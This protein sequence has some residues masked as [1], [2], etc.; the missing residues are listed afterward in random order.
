M[1]LTGYGAEDVPERVDVAASDSAARLAEV[2]ALITG[3]DAEYRAGRL[4]ATAYARQVTALEA[5]RADLEARPFTY[6]HTEWRPSGEKFAV[7][8]ER[9][10]VPARNRLLR[11]L[12]ARAVWGGGY[13]TANL[14]TFGRLRIS[15]IGESG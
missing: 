13:L 5:E 9:L 7:R 12:D 4:P 11:D 1:L 8:W 15:A 2:T 14:R 3:L 6:A 10:D